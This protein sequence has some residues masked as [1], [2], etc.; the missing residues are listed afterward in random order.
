[1]SQGKML[2]LQLCRHHPLENRGLNGMLCIFKFV[3]F[4]QQYQQL[5][6][7][8]E[9]L[10]YICMIILYL[11]SHLFLVDSPSWICWVLCSE[12]E[13]F[14][15]D[16][17]DINHVLHI[18]CKNSGWNCLLLFQI[19]YHF[20]RVRSSVWK[21]MGR[22]LGHRNSRTMRVRYHRISLIHVC[23]IIH[24]VPQKMTRNIIWKDF[25]AADK[26]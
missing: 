8:K 9:H 23:F 22:N 20:H 19:C 24:L 14:N 1:M 7:N 17:C 12:V 26:L 21:I 16:I 18:A 5:S 25:P 4:N 15:H 13:I 10:S 11:N 3:F 6:N 2:F